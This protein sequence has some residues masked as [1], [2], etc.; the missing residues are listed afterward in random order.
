M[1]PVCLPVAN[2]KWFESKLK[3]VGV[4]GYL[5]CNNDDGDDDD[6]INTVQYGRQVLKTMKEKLC[7]SEFEAAVSLTNIQY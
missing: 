2:K 5:G 1:Q 4:N 7:K 3:I 6:G